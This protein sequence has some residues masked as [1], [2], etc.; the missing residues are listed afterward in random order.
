MGHG[1]DWNN[2]ALGGGKVPY[3]E[4][5]PDPGMDCAAREM[6]IPA[7]LKQIGWNIEELQGS[8]EALS[9]RLSPLMNKNMVNAANTPEKPTDALPEMAQMLHRYNVAMAGVNRHIRDILNQLE[10]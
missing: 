3:V 8:M 9:N 1:D 4:S 5:R 10:I 6:Y 2:K 7:E